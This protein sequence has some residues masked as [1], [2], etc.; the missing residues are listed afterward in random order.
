[1]HKICR[2][3]LSA[4]TRTC[5]ACGSNNPQVDF[6]DS[7]W[8]KRKN[9]RKF[10]QCMQGRQCVQCGTLAARS[11]FAAEEWDKPDDLRKCFTCMTKVCSKCEMDKSR[12]IIGV[13]NGRSQSTRACATIATARLA[14]NAQYTSVDLSS[15]PLH[16]SCR[17]TT[18]ASFAL[19]VWRVKRNTVIGLVL[20]P[21]VANKSLS[22]N[23]ALYVRSIK[24]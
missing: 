13:K 8:R 9:D 3:C 5:I 2:A 18:Q 14:A 7:K 21:S 24:L 20:I 15:K 11:S 10:K 17:I 22:T 19:C 4:K 23:S 12:G 6:T 1:M 16:G